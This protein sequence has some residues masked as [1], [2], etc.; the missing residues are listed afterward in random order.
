M[1]Q[2]LFA[3]KWKKGNIANKSQEKAKGCKH[4]GVRSKDGNPETFVHTPSSSCWDR[5]PVEIQVKI[6]ALCSIHDLL[7]LKLV[8]RAFHE[9][10]TV[11]E[12]SIARQ[13]LRRRR[14]GTLPST[15]SKE[16]TYTRNPEDDVVLLS[17]LFPPKSS[18]KG[19]YLYTFRYLHSLRRKQY[20]CTRLC[21][22]LANR[23]MDRFLNTQQLWVKAHFPS[24]AERNSIFERGTINLQYNLVPLSYCMLYFLETYA[25][26]R[27]EHTN[28]LLR[29]YEAGR[30]PVP[31]PL[32]V[33]RTMY[34][35]LQAR[36]L[37]SPPFTD[38]PTLI[39]THHCMHLLVSYLRHTIPP[40]DHGP[41]DDHWIGALLTISGLGRI[42]DF[43]SAEIGDGGNPR[44]QRRD[45]MTRFQSDIILNER[46]EMNPHIYERVP[47]GQYHYPS[48]AEVWFDVASQELRRR[49]AIP[50]DAEN[51]SVWN[52]MPVLIGCEHCRPAF[53]WKA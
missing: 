46:E 11:H 37:Q 22:Y 38:T 8:C 31:I 12:Q 13:Y 17:D 15:I 50:H 47:E 32:H 39:A 3:S 18:A 35:E 25:L 24:K 4:R 27:K 40:D 9:V 48:P 20:V 45:F 6:F 23:V 28:S 26:A 53:G 1:M 42:V 43:F 19:G 2:F 29:H 44:S 49:N 36:I 30:L 16:R 7:P 21:H 51:F 10:L 52:G 5:L 33:R 41:A 14:H 34:A